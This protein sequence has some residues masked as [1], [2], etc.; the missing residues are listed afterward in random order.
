MLLRF[1]A[2][3]SIDNVPPLYLMVSIRSL[4]EPEFLQLQKEIHPNDGWFQLE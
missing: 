1:V 4:R 3:L 2:M